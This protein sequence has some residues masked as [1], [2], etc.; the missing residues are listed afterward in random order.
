MDLSQQLAILRPRLRLIVLVTVIAGVLSFILASLIPKTYEAHATLLVGQVY[1]TSQP[2]QPAQLNYDSFLASQELA[3]TFAQLADTRPF[4]AAV[5][6]GLHLSDDP[7]ALRDRVDAQAPPGSLFITVSARASSETSAAD[8]ANQVAKELLAEAPGILV[9][10]DAT[11]AQS[12]VTVVDPAVASEAVKSPKVPLYAALGALTALIVAVATIFVLAYRESP[13]S[14]RGPAAR[15]VSAPEPKSAADPALG[16]RP[17]AALAP[18]VAPIVAEARPAAPTEPRPEPLSYQPTDPLP[19]TE[20]SRTTPVMIAQPAPLAET[21]PGGSSPANV[22]LPADDGPLIRPR[23]APPRTASSKP[24]V[25][26]PTAAPTP[27]PAA[28]GAPVQGKGELP[29]R[30]AGAGKPAAASKAGPAG[31]PERASQPVAAPNPASAGKGGSPARTAGAGK[32]AALD[33]TRPRT[34][35][36]PALGPRSSGD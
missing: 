19:P 20:V 29:V 15:R 11:K 10:A 17:S 32:P 16:S 33:E 13:Q 23:I 12:I 1:T 14:R 6:T 8:L 36:R 28:A 25:P 26:V 4:L 24:A 21:R 34:R 30:T 18:I 35:A 7:T 3:T 5:A 9:G 2:S 22:A 27:E 31:K